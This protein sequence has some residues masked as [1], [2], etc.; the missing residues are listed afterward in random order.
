MRPDIL[1][2]IFVESTAL[3]G[4]GPAVAK[5]L[6]RL[7]LERAVDLAFHLPVGW[8]ERQRVRRLA[9][10]ETGRMVGV[11]LTATG[12]EPVDLHARHSE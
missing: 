4:V 8:I 7:G 1:N 5:P 9:E 11:V 3:N 10:A 6:A 12:I 2:P